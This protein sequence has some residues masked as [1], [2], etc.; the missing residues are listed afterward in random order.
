M[1]G[2]KWI[3]IYVDMFDNKKIR[4]I[5]KLPDGN[6]ILLCWI[7]LLTSAGKCNS[8]GFIF[9][10][11]NVPYTVE[12]LSNEY[13]IPLNTVKLAIETLK[14]L[15]M[16]SDEDGVFCISSWDEYQ[17]IE[18][19]ERVKA[20]NRE[21]NKRYREKKKELLLN[22]VSVT[23][24]DGTDIDIDK[25]YIYGDFFESIWKLYPKKKGK[26][27]IS[28][29]QKMKLY[30]IGFDELSRC[31]ERYKKA[32]ADTDEKFIQHGSTF[33]NS[34]YVDYLDKNYTEQKP[35]QQGR[36]KDMSNYEP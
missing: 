3:K 35:E 20:L 30:K 6:D 21:R 33:F 27:Q 1:A 5:R 12:M 8:N 10:T 24:H 15:N 2:V 4:F 7:M 31:I 14:K 26:G 36:Y 19:M 23:S 25:E 13:D 22:D 16:I 28:K 9:L 11:E 17:N 34:G 18:G 32:I 29:S